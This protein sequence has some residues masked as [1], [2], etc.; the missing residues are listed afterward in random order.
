MDFLRLIES[1][2]YITVSKELARNIGLDETIILTELISKYNYW[3]DNEQLK[4]G[5]F[6]ITIKDLK[7][8]TTLTKYR[9]TKAI[10]NLKDL[11]LIKTKKQGLPAKRYFTICRE[12]IKRLFFNLD[13]QKS[14]KN[15]EKVYNPRNDL[16]VKNSKT[17][18]GKIRKLKV[19]NSTQLRTNNKK[20]YN[21]EE[22]E[23]N[24]NLS[25]K[26]ENLFKNTFNRSIRNFEIKQL[27]EY[28]FSEEIIQ[29]AIKLASIYG[30]NS[31]AYILKI[32]DDWKKNNIKNVEDVDD[33]IKQYKNKKNKTDDETLEK[34]Y[35]KG[36][37]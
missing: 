21:E 7:K 34:M 10:N 18:D 36:Y 16:E 29:K 37:R 25:T 14:I 12:D 30:G 31:L 35:K 28:Q 11:G 1:K 26:T 6:Y 27:S 24:L 8:E 19:K 4:K 3:R 9:Q 15:A 13:K 5:Y 17:S 32:L 2:G 22:E 23:I 33:L 20:Y